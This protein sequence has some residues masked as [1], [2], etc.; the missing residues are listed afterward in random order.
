MAS[1]PNPVRRHT[2]VLSQLSVKSLVAVS[3]GGSPESLRTPGLTRCSNCSRKS[4]VASHAACQSPGSSF[5]IS[6]RCSSPPFSATIIVHVP[7]GSCRYQPRRLYSPISTDQ[8]SRGLSSA[9]FVSSYRI[10][11]PL[12]VDD[13]RRGAC[14]RVARGVRGASETGCCA[15]E[16]ERC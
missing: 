8:T 12:H 13:G 6:L 2:L 5:S 9:R 7:G 15:C 14:R 3:R 16:C 10:M 11:I 4:A 1:D